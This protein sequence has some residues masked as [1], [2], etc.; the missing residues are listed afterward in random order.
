VGSTAILTHSLFAVPAFLPPLRKVAPW[1][2]AT[3]R[4]REALSKAHILLPGW[5][6]Q[7]LEELQNWQQNKETPFGG[8]VNVKNFR[9]EWFEEGCFGR[10]RKFLSQSIRIYEIWRT[11]G[12][13][14]GGQLPVELARVIVE[15]LANHECLPTENLRN[16][17][18]SKK[19]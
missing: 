3:G 6:D 19:K 16:V 2:A 10:L 5:I 8:R 15:D 4:T 9:A 11:M 14:G 7:D 1:D 17:Y 18:S 12:L 13:C